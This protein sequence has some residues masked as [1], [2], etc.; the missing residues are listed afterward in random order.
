MGQ[1]LERERRRMA[2][3]SNAGGGAFPVARLSDKD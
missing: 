3:I 2:L 1:L